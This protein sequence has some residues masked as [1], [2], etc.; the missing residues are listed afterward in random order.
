MQNH[1]DQWLVNVFVLIKVFSIGILNEHIHNHNR[2]K[3]SQ[4]CYE[5]KNPRR[6]WG[7]MI[8]LNCEYRKNVLYM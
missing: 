4:V 5:Q 7:L 3:N 2:S 1:I 8:S 6:I